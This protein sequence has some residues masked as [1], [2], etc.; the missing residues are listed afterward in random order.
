MSRS[1]GKYIKIHK[2]AKT[3]DY[4]EETLQGPRSTL[5]TEFGDYFEHGMRTDVG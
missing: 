4:S 1:K 2:C 3:P 5:R